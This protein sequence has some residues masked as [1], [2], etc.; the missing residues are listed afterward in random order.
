MLLTFCCPITAPHKP[1]NAISNH[2]VFLLK[3]VT[4]TPA[5]HQ[6]PDTWIFSRHNLRS[7]HAPAPQA[8]IVAAWYRSERGQRGYCLLLLTATTKRLR[9]FAW[10]LEHVGEKQLV[11]K[12]KISSITASRLLKRKQTNHAPSRSQRLLPKWSRITNEVFYS[13]MLITLASDEQWKQ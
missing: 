12:Q 9:F 7:R 10:V 8:P 3:W 6:Q 5:T 13:L 2:V 1:F 4:R 11:W